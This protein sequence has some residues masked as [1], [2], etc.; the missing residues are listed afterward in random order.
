MNYMEQVAQM[1]GVNFDEEFNLSG[2]SYKCKITK[3]GMFFCFEGSHK[4][5]KTRCDL[6]DILTGKYKIIKKPILDEA[7]KRYLSNVIKPFR[8]KIKYIAKYIDDREYISII[9]K[10]LHNRTFSMAFPSYD[11]GTMY[12]GMELDK[13]YSLEDLGL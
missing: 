8:N 13:Q 3:E 12:K 4:W 10:D 6:S 9:Y 2:I 1:L 5:Y 7:E 11:D